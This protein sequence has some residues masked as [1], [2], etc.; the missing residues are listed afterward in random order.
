MFD[1]NLHKLSGVFCSYRTFGNS[2]LPPPTQAAQEIE[3]RTEGMRS[4]HEAQKRVRMPLSKA[5]LQI[6][7]DRVDGERPLQT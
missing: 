1:L 5:P 6:A 2:G 3:A 4:Y 7:V